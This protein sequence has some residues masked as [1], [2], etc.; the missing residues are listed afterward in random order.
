MSEEF[1]FDFFV[2][3]ADAIS[4]LSLEFLNI[5]AYC[6]LFELH[7]ALVSAYSMLLSDQVFFAL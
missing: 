4:Q 5:L 1:L 2:F 7:H 6:F 3:F